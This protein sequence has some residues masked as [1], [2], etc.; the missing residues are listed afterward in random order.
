MYAIFVTPTDAQFL[1]YL[2]SIITAMGCLIGY[3]FGESASGSTNTLP[4]IG[5]IGSDDDEQQDDD[6]SGGIKEAPGITFDN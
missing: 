3:Y 2:Q 6:L 4:I 1:D 5:I